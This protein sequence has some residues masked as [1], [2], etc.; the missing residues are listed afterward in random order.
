MRHKLDTDSNPF[1]R[2]HSDSFRG[3]SFHS[4]CEHIEHLLVLKN[5]PLRRSAYRML[6]VEGA[7]HGRQI[8]QAFAL[9]ESRPGSGVEDV[10]VPFQFLRNYSRC[11]I[12]F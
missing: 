7:L 6:R 2:L 3:I 9:Q 12:G 1:S 5:G 11:F 8:R 10:A 4:S